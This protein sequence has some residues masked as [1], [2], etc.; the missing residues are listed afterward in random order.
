METFRW[1]VEAINAG[2][3]LIGAY[4]WSP[5]QNFEWLEAMKQNFGIFKE[6]ELSLPLIPRIDTEISS[7]EALK[8]SSDAILRPDSYSAQRFLRNRMVA[9]RRFNTEVKRRTNAKNQTS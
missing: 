1:M 7:W 5:V 3:P 4:Y 8:T 6:A 2:V 9:K